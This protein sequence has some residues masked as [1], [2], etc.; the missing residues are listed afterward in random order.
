MTTITIETDYITLGQL[1]KDAGVIDSGG[2]AK[3][4]LADNQ[5]LVNGDVETRRG[6]KLRPGDTAALPD[7]QEF[8]VAA[9]E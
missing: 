6:R 4:F 7:G 3:F 9:V 5:V 2:A 8:T 1:L